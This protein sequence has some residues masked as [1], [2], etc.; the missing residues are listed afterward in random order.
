M[1]ATAPSSSSSSSAAANQ[2]LALGH[3]NVAES[4]ADL[5]LK[6][7]AVIKDSSEGLEALDLFDSP[8]LE[9]LLPVY[10]TNLGED[11]RSVKTQMWDKAYAP[12]W[13]RKAW[14]LRLVWNKADQNEKVKKPE[15]RTAIE[16]FM[17]THKDAIDAQEQKK[18]FQT[19][20][21]ELI[22]RKAQLLKVAAKHY[23][24]EDW[25]D[26]IDELFPAIPGENIEKGESFARLL[27]GKEYATAKHFLKCLA[28]SDV[29]QTHKSVIL[30]LYMG[31][32]I[33]AGEIQKVAV[34]EMRQKLIEK[35]AKVEGKFPTM[36]EGLNPIGKELFAKIKAL[37]TKDKE[38]EKIAK[39]KKKEEKLKKHAEKAKANSKEVA[40]A[41]A[42]KE[43]EKAKDRKDEKSDVPPPAPQPAPAPAPSVSASA[44]TEA[45]K[46]AGLSTDDIANK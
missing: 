39:C 38:K 26:T 28:A 16:K 10:I 30:N 25:S 27:Q 3:L 13:L 1:S 40:I 12:T 21:A 6:L 34:Q 32:L 8:D 17:V 23:P 36:M 37:G 41:A 35:M 45:E 44:Q 42:A 24:G 5:Q 7:K 20:G 46:A 43:A 33:E 14:K 22:F 29:I 18:T 9:Q 2:A 19:A 31:A 4:P 11:S 15:V